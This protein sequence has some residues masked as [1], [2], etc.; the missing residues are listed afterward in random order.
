MDAF[1]QSLGSVLLG[2]LVVWYVGGWLLR[3]AAASCFVCAAGLLAL[4]DVGSAA[5][6]AG[7]GAAC[8][9]VGEILLRLRHG[10]WRSTRAAR[11]F[12]AAPGGT[13]RCGAAR[14]PG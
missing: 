8:W 3:L 7:C 10:W 9:T 11:L 6:V 14:P 5:G 1:I 12:R 13:S 2:G 4:G